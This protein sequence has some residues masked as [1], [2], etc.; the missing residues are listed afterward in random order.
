MLIGVS[1]KRHYS[2]IFTIIRNNLTHYHKFL[3][4]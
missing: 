1:N 4:Y 3:L 2:I